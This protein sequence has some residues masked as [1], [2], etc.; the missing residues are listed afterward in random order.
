MVKQMF[1]TSISTKPSYFVSPFSLELYP[2]WCFITIGVT[3]KIR[4]L[5]KCKFTRENLRER[6]KENSVNKYG[7]ICISTER[8]FENGWKSMIWRNETRK[9]QIWK[10]VCVGN[11]HVLKE[12]GENGEKDV[13]AD[14]WNDPKTILKSNN[15][16]LLKQLVSSVGN[17]LSCLRMWAMQ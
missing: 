8:P 2:R 15:P 7:F 17:H 6:W 12:R 10:S 5:Q 4:R 3:V 9:Q 16:F 1:L 13:H 14:G 11:K